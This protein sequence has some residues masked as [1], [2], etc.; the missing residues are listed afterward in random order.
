MVLKQL[1]RA[2]ET[3]PRERERESP[4]SDI[5]LLLLLSHEFR[6]A[7][8]SVRLINVRIASD[9]VLSPFRLSYT[10]QQLF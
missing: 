2:A 5:V 7:L 3:F 4:S 8:K 6:C 9:I 10:S 1:F